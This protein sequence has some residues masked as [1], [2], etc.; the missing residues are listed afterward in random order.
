MIKNKTG[1]VKSI[2]DGSETILPEKKVRLLPEV[3]LSYKLP[4]AYKQVVR[5]CTA[6]ATAGML[7]AIYRKQPS[8]LFM[9]FNGRLLEMTYMYD[10]G[11]SIKKCIEG[12]MLFGLCQ[13]DSWPYLKEKVLDAPTLECYEEGESWKITK[14]YVMNH[15]LVAMRRC[16]ASGYCFVF[17]MSLYDSYLDA[18]TTGVVTMPKRKGDTYRGEHAVCAVGYHHKTKQFIIRNSKG[19]GWGDNGY[20][21]LPYAYMNPRL[22]TDIWTV[23]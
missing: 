4:P 20:F 9:Y 6:E 17:G 3:D 23:R 2:L 21:L 16:L 11:C 12:T 18:A 8:R 10:N 15:G 1:F 13:G 5:D 22:T 7:Y 19:P 14:S